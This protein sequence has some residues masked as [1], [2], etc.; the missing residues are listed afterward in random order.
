VLHN[1]RQLADVLRN[2]PIKQGEPTRRFLLKA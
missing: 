1:A 2:V